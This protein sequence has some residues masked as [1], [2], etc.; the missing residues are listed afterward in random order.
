TLDLS[1][2]RFLVLDEAD[3]MLTMGFADEVEAILAETPAEK[4]V[5][6]FCATWPQQI[7]RLAATYLKDPVEVTIKSKT[8]TAP[9]IR[10]RRLMAS[11]PQ[12]VDA[13]T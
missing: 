1:H 4:Q 11:F 6:L 2:L 5:A 3:E 7:R 12:K 9:N 10:Q 13:L 8:T